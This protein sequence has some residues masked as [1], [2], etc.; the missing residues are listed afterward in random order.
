MSKAVQLLDLLEA[1]RMWGIKGGEFNP[2][3]KQTKA[4]EKEIRKALKSLPAN[5]FKT[6]KKK[7]GK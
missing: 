4:A 5:A 7:V 6:K 2:T 1:S 3:P